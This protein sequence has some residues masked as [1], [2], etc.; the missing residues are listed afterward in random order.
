[1]MNIKPSP[2]QVLQSAKNILLVDWPDQGVPRTLL[3]AG[4]SV[5]GFSPEGFALAGLADNMPEGEERFAP[6]ND[7][8]IGYLV[9]KSLKGGPGHIDIVNIYRPEAEHAK[10]IEHLVLPLRAK[11]VWLHP[12]VTS[13]QTGKIAAKNGLIF[14][15]GISI[16]EIAGSV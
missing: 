4:F 13:A 11:A 14:I 15:E 7:N 9:F 16:A 6:R 8:E 12:P 1:M 10:I 2:L 5:Y 3:K